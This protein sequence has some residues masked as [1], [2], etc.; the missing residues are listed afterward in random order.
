MSV[1]TDTKFV[2][3]A[4]HDHSE[5]ISK[6][7]YPMLAD[8]TATLCKT[9]NTYNEELGESVRA[10][11]IYNPD[12]ELMAYEMHHDCIGRNID[13]IFRK[14]QAAD[15]VRKN[16]GGIV[17]PARWQPGDKTLKPGVKMVGK[18]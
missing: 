2:H 8:P 5:A 11:F 4:W 6:V 9:L 12:Q 18:I 7:T 13:E 15:H 17:C 1:S 16:G 3:K 14:V 10:T